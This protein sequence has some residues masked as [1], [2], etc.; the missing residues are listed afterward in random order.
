MRRGFES[1]R[2]LKTGGTF[3]EAY[4]FKRCRKLW[5]NSASVGQAKRY[6][7]WQ[8]ITNELNNR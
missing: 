4:S 7:I 5:R 6:C 1:I 8:V 2:E 3:L